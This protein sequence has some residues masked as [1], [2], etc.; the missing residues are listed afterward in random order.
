[1]DKNA[2]LD[3]V[4]D[5]SMSQGFYGRLYNLLTSPQG[6]NYLD[7]LVEQNFADPINLILFLE[8]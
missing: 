2:I 6:S 5:M 3:F 1:M 7:Y 4:R 8:S